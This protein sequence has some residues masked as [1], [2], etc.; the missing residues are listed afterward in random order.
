MTTVNPSAAIIVYSYIDRGGSGST[1]NIA[2]ETISITESII[3]IDTSKTKSRPAGTFDVKLAPSRNWIA[4]IAPGSW[5]EIHMSTRKITNSDF[6]KPS[7]QTLKMIGIIDS[8]RMSVAVDQ[9]TGARSTVYSLVGRDWGAALES[10][11]YIDSALSSSA[12]SPLIKAINLLSY[13]KLN[14]SDVIVTGVFSPKDMIRKILSVWGKGMAAT[15]STLMNYN[16]FAQYKLPIEVAAKLNNKSVF[17]SDQIRVVSGKLTGKDDYQSVTD[18]LGVFNPQSLVGIN[19]VWQLINVHSNNILNEL[20]ADMRWVDSYPSM[21]LYHRI[22]PFNV[23]GTNILGLSSNFFNVKQVQ[24]PTYDVMGIDLGDNTQDIVNFIEILPN[25]SISTLPANQVQGIIATIKPKSSEIDTISLSR[26]GLKPLVYSSLFAPASGSVPDWSKVIS[27]LPLVKD[28]YFDC[29]KMLN[30]TVAILGQDKFIGVGDNIVL[31]SQI[32][33]KTDFVNASN[34]TLV[35]HVESVRHS[36]RYDINSGRTFTTTINFVRGVMANKSASA[37]AN[38]DAFGI[39]TN[40]K[41]L[42]VD[43][44]KIKNIYSE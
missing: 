40:S 14:S 41:L 22:K 36:F 25:A 37:L 3:S 29:H 15:A 5:V 19:T 20:V 31:D 30:G 6:L 1:K 10:F 33:G 4:S 16:L 18:S 26:Y 28:W 13:A 23:K 17:L 34:T 27:W 24:I 8:I 7:E 38:P 44:T 12:E 2:C 42:P 32:L 35:A 9:T 43:K 21:C 11:L 39:H